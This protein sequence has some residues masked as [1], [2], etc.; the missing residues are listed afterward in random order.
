M[1]SGDKGLNPHELAHKRPWDPP[2]IRIKAGR[3]SCDMRIAV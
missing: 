3:K 2:A 1:M